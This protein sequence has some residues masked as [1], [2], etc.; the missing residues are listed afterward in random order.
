MDDYS[1]DIGKI[2]GIP[3]YIVK[4]TLQLLALAMLHDVA[5]KALEGKNQKIIVPYI[6]EMEIGETIDVSLDNKFKRM[7]EEATEGI[8]PLVLEA[9]KKMIEKIKARYPKE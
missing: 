6:C 7:Y 3:K 4:N 9:E 5:E 1:R 2:L 8:S